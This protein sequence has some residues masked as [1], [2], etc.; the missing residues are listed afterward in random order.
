MDCHTSEKAT[1]MQ[2][3][4]EKRTQELTFNGYWSEATGMIKW[5]PTIIYNEVIYLKHREINVL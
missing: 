5:V 1:Q 3:A 4:A 2:L